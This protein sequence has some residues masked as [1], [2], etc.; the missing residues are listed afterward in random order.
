MI[1]EEKV[2]K[3]AKGA[4]LK[5][6][7]ETL[8]VLKKLHEDITNE[9]DYARRKLRENKTQLNN[10][11]CEIEGFKRNNAEYKQAIIKA[12]DRTASLQHDICTMVSKNVR[13]KDEKEQMLEL[14]GELKTF[15]SEKFFPKKGVAPVEVPQWINADLQEQS[16]AS[17][18]A[19]R[20]WINAGVRYKRHTSPTR[21]FQRSPTEASEAG[22]RRSDTRSTHST[23]HSVPRQQFSR[24]DTAPHPSPVPNP[25]FR[26]PVVK[27][28]EL[29]RA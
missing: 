29:Y 20:A 19:N 18:D 17:R 13:L 26:S 7:T 14:H 24:Y 10:A 3:K 2:S 8:E 25:V 16:L 22:F 11:L 5:E 23:T 12:D 4:K 9:N 21:S 27:G 28:D 15:A 1:H 6:V